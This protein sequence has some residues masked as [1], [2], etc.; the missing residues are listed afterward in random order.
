[1][2]MSFPH[3]SGQPIIIGGGIAG[4]LTALHFAP[5]PVLLLSKSPLGADTSSAWAQG[6]LAASFASDDNPALHLAD[7]LTAGDG[8]CNAEVARHIVHAAPAAIENL[9]RLGVCFDRKSDGA[10]WLGLEAAHS[11]RRIVHAK[12]DGSGREIMRALVAA[13][14]STPSIVVIEGIEARRVMTEANAVSGVLAYGATGPVFFGTGRIVLATGGIGGLFFD[15][16]NPL[17]SFGQGLALAAHAGAALADLEFIQFHPTAFDAPGRPMSLISEAARGEGA[18]LVDETGR[19]FLGGL[20]GAE[21]APRDILTRAVWQHMAKGHNIFLD[22]RQKSISG[23]AERFPGIALVCKTFNIDPARDLVPIRPAQHY[24][25]GGVAVDQ[26][27]RSSV[28]GLWACGEVACTG[29]HGANR[30]ASNS[31]TEAA[32][33]AR[34]VAESIAGT[35]SGRSMRSVTMN[36]PSP[37]PAAVRPVISRTLGVLKEYEGL[38]EAASALLPVAESNDAAADPAVVGLMIAVAALQREESRGAHYRTDFPEHAAVPRRSKLYLDDAFA[39]AREL[40]SSSIRIA[41]RA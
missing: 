14:R 24:H 16:T 39:A 29:L 13:V 32:V 19:R 10:L 41:K 31:L 28:A 38:K 15:T 37:D 22:V 4:L 9:S 7:T 18:V 11:R 25:M 6:G 36:L 1:M 33:C 27:G 17:G 3:L 5:A 23:I 40:G 26:T 21:L 20:Q 8:L 2:S 34:W 12:G 30:L 35:L